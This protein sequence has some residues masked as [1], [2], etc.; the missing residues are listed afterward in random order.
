VE[1]EVGPPGAAPGTAPGAAQDAPPDRDTLV[2]AWGD[3]VLRGLPAKAKAL[4]SAGRFV[5]VTDGSAAFALPNEAHRDRC[6]DVQG[7]VEGALAAHFGTP[8]P[9]RLVV[10]GAAGAERPPARGAPTA[11][12]GEEDFEPG[13]PGQGEAVESGAE[14]RLLQAFPGAHEVGE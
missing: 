5:E 8:V 11:G 13:G 14:A 1:T 4:Y 2:Q 12:A 6:A 3:Q 9:L 7:V 10:E